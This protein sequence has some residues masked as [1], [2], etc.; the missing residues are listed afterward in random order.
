M[1]NCFQPTLFSNLKVFILTKIIQK[2]TSSKSVNYTFSFQCYCKLLLFLFVFLC[3]KNDLN[4][5][6][7]TLIGLHARKIIKTKKK[8]KQIEKWTLYK[9]WVKSSWNSHSCT[10]Q[11]AASDILS[12][13][14]WLTW[15]YWP[16]TVAW[17]Y[18]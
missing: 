4:T 8:V 16:L 1:E 3:S 6:V 12:S 13:D 14:G 7:F 10:T 11:I 5:K 15:K 17:L 18:H 2:K 9:Y